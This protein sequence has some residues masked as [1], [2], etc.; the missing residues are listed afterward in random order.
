MA[1]PSSSPVGSFKPALAI[2][3]T[4]TTAPIT[5]TGPTISLSGITKDEMQIIMD[6]ADQPTLDALGQVFR[7]LDSIKLGMQIVTEESRE[8][9]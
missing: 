4:V 3:I 1:Y 7:A 8:P 2:P 9:G 6:G 5:V